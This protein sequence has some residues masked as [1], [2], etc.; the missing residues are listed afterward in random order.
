[1]ARIDYVEDSVYTEILGAPQ[2]A[3]LLRAI[4]NAPPW[5]EAFVRLGIVQM[6]RSALPLESRADLHPHGPQAPHRLYSAQPPRWRSKIRADKRANAG[7]TKTGPCPRTFFAAPAQHSG[8]RRCRWTAG[9]GRW[10]V[11]AGGEIPSERRG[12]HRGVRA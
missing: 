5:A 9:R 4:F 8:P 1:M 11:G 6:T 2:T 10:C 12:N 3:N 7:I